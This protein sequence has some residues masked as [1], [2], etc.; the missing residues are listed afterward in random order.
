MEGL[1]AQFSVE[2]AGMGGGAGETVVRTSPFGPRNV[3]QPFDDVDVTCTYGMFA[4]SAKK[5]PDN[6]CIGWRSPSGERPY[7]FRSYSHMFSVVNRLANAFAALGLSKGDRVG[8][9]GKNCPAWSTVQYAVNAAGLVVV[10]IYDSLGPN[11]VEYV[12]NHAEVKL[13]CVSPANYKGWIAAKSVC[14]TVRN[15]VM[16]NVLDPEEDPVP[17]DKTADLAGVVNLPELL[18]KG[19]DDTKSLP[20][21][22][23]SDLNVIMYT[24][25]TTGNPKGVMLKNSCLV[26]SV[27]SAH[28]FFAHFGVPFRSTDVFLSYLPLSHIFEQQAEA[29]IF[30]TGGRVGYFTGDIKLLLGDM[31]MLRPTIF[32]GV[33]RVFARFQQRI[34][35]NVEKSG[36]L[37]KMLFDWAYARQVRAAEEPLTI[38]RNPIWDALVMK[39]VRNKLLPDVRLVITGSAPMSSQTNDFLK[40]CLQAPVVQGYGLTETVG[41]L[42]CSAPDRSKSG[43]CGGPLPGSFVKLLDL[44]EMGYL[45]TDK[46][47]PRGEVCVKGAVVFSG[48]YKNEEATAAVLD[49]D[50]WF[51]TGDVGRWNEDGSLQIIDRAKNL[52]KL[53]QGEY[54][55]PDL[56]EQEY[57]K[58]KL[59][60]QIFVYGDSLQSTLMAV[61][62][63]DIPNAM[64]WG[65]ANGAIASIEAIGKND[66]FKKEVLAQLVEINIKAK[67]KKYE[68]VVDIV[69]ETEGLN[70]LGQGFSVENDLMT[71]SFKLKRPQIRQKYKERLDALYEAHM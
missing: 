28:I 61:V 31:E 7:V 24:S 6:G 66:A 53:S 64:E 55:A 67:F 54:V 50:G 30:S 5:Y 69:M 39:K 15:V 40:T 59:V 52:F 32:A 9:Y 1:E 47:Y 33:P 60:G 23:L 26:S 58:A 62:V 25:G 8:V 12:C 18:Q 46:P 65:H 48:Y 70:E 37:K 38:S 63:P 44:P 71:P 43:H 2:V 41:G 29:L 16:F 68:R 17:E 27:A 19:S 49:E 35:E 3:E 21:V 36:G 13:I 57:Q 51:R 42:T 10:P 14:S 11:T 34:Q 4:Y 20:E 56:L 45:S 22:A